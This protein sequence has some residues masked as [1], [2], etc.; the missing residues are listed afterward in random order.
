MNEDVIIK[1]ELQWWR[2]AAGKVVPGIVVKPLACPCLL[3]EHE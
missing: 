3:D 1:A 2:D